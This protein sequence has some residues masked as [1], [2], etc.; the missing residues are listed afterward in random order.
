MIELNITLFVLIVNF[1]LLMFVLSRKLF[2][3][4]LEHLDQRDETIHGSLRNAKEMEEKS[5]EKFREYK[6]KLQEEKRN[7]IFEQSRLREELLDKQKEIILTERKEAESKISALSVEI[8][9]QIESSRRDFPK[10]A[11]VLASQIADAITG[12]K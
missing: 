8:S 12:K 3:P 10:L 6:A 4:M 7:V 5:E 1:L 11:A 2:K 9:R